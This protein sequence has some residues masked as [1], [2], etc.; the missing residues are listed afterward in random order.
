M[1]NVS[2][3]VQF[4]VA[5]LGVIFCIMIIAGIK[6][7][8]LT[9]SGMAGLD[10]AV[11]ISL[12]AI[13]VGI[14][15]ALIFGVITTLSEGAKAK[16]T[17]FGIGAFVGLSIAVFATASSSI[18]KGVKDGVIDASTAQ[19]VSGGIHL[20]LILLFVAVIAIV[21]GEVRSLLS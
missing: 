15:A 14:A 17:L 4:A 7:N 18:P 21:V 8:S 6:D 19:L 20:F 1:K 9:D 3:I 16:G 5:I 13:V 10:G 12:I 11:W 2:K